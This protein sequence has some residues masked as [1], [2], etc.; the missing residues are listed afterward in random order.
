MHALASI[1][2]AVFV[3]SAQSGDEEIF[4]RVRA[5]WDQGQQVEALKACKE[6]IKNYPNSK[7]VPDAYLMFGEYYFDQAKLN[8]ALMAYK[9]VTQYKDS[10]VYSYALYKTGWCYFNT[11]EFKRALEQ[12]VAVVKHC[13]K[14]EQATGQK[15]KL[16]LEAL[17]D[18]TLAYSHA[19]KASAAPA[20]FKRLAPNETG[21]L[22]PALAGMYFGD[23]KYK[24]AMDVYRHL[25]AKAGCSVEGP[26]LQLKIIDCVVRAGVMQNVP[27]EVRKLAEL[28]AKLETCLPKPTD[29]QKEELGQARE[30][31][32]QTLY[33]LAVFSHEEAAATK[34]EKTSRLARELAESYL[35]LFPAS[36]RSAEI[37]GLLQ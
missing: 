8:K 7:Y 4:K 11:H 1:L 30:A 34:D 12:F 5:L 6:L 32:E 24:D 31:A 16:R 37:R 36:Q 19:G 23:G 18:A 2:L 17:N 3:L 13:D 10:K 15:S 9:K 28:F 21:K 22:L 25:I 26:T 35:K 33:D 27:P 20:F 29:D 14:E